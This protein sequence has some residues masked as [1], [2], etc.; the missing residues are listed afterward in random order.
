[1]RGFLKLACFLVLAATGC[2]GDGSDGPPITEPDDDCL[3]SDFV[4]NR[5]YFLAGGPI[6]GPPFPLHRYSFC[7]NET[8]GTA[9]Y[10]QDLAD[11]G[12]NVHATFSL[13]FSNFEEPSGPAERATAVYDHTAF[14]ARTDFAVENALSK[15]LNCRDNIRLKTEFII[16]D[17][18]E[19]DSDD[20][21]A[22]E[23]PD[24]EIS[25]EDFPC[26]INV[27]PD[28]VADFP[29]DRVPDEVY[30]ITRGSSL[31][32]GLQRA[33]EVDFVSDDSLEPGLWIPSMFFE[34]ISF[35]TLIPACGSVDPPPD[36]E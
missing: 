31:V 23:A 27:G 16:D 36:E 35:E 10:A 8:E 30:S 3:I 9:T 22:I 2:G 6:S 24:A 33:A 25:S 17:C 11:A 1:M 28:V 29:G 21:V 15:W 13:F 26:G 19:I 18:F 32:E 20:V 12:E 5:E 34:E 4:V 7:I 14:R